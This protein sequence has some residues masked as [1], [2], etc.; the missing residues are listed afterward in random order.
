MIAAML[1]PWVAIL[2]GATTFAVYL[3]LHLR[4][5]N[6]QDASG[7]SLLAGSVLL[8]VLQSMGVAT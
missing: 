3:R 2:V 1:S 5:V 8:L 4:K 7:L 6:E